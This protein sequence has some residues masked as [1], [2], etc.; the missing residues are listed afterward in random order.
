MQAATGCGS[1][2]SAA[3]SRKRP[4]CYQI[5]A[6]YKAQLSAELQQSR[7]LWQQYLPMYVC[8]QENYE[9]RHVEVNDGRTNLPSWGDGPGRKHV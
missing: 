7:R 8:N 1:S 9:H 3:F 5:C 6:F 2:S 4:R